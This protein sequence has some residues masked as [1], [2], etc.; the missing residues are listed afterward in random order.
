M[1]RRPPH[2]SLVMTTTALVQGRP[3]AEYLGVVAAQTII[4]ANAVRDIVAG[5][6][7]FLGGRSRSYE[8]LLQKARDEALQMMEDEAA[9]LGADA[10]IGIDLDFQTLG[11]QSSLIMVSASGTAVRFGPDTGAALAVR[12]A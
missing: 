11:P 8:R 3:V 5:F 1:A 9:G 10:V 2:A 4:G 7:D 12:R 6:R